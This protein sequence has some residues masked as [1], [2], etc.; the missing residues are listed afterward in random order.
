MLEHEYYKWLCRFVMTSR[1]RCYRILMRYL[2]QTPFVVVVDMDDNRYADGLELRSTFADEYGYSDEDIKHAMGDDPCNIL[3]VMLALA[4]RCENNIMEDT[5]VGDRTDKWFW[6]M[7]DNSYLGT[8][9]DDAFDAKK[10]DAIIH[11]IIY[12]T[13]EPNGLGGLFR[14]KYPPE[15]LRTVELWYQLN[16]YLT[17]YIEEMS[18]YEL[19]KKGL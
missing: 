15:D 2:Y 7:I 13:Y 11:R 4:I 3:E 1:R 16:W 8:L 9:T 14:L 18:V 6:M 17:E 12:R 5:S 10:A 19:D